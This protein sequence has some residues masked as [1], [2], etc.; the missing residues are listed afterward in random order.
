MGLGNSNKQEN[1]NRDRMPESMR[2]KSLWGPGARG[3]A[4]NPTFGLWLK[5]G[6]KAD[7]YPSE[8][9]APRGGT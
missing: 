1:K 7:A 9:V 5:L 6:S 8:G 2:A 4:P 3:V